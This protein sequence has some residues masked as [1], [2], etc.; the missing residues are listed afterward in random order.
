MKS[1]LLDG[2]DQIKNSALK[3]IVCVVP[4]GPLTLKYAKYEQT[5]DLKSYPLPYFSRCLKMTL[6]PGFNELI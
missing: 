5:E 4:G 2:L 6:L 3:F 1:L